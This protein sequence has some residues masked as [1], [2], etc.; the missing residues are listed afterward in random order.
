MRVPLLEPAVTRWE[1][2]NCDL[3]DTTRET[4]L[5]TRF[6]ACKGLAGLTAPMVREGER[7][8]VT[9]REREDYIGAEDVRYDANGRPVAQVVT[10]RPDGSND[11]IVFAPT[12]H[13]RIS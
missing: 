3:R 7:L 12:A 10:E 1:C 13:A 2:P 5:H 8:K 9:A 6:H 11:V 4:Q